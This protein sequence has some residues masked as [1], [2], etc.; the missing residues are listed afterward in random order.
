MTQFLIDQGLLQRETTAAERVT[1][2]DISQRAI[3]L[4]K[5]TLNALGLT[6]PIQKLLLSDDKIRQQ[7]GLEHGLDFEDIDCENTVVVNS[8]DW[9]QLYGTDGD[10]EV[11]AVVDYLSRMAAEQGF[12]VVVDWPET[13]YEGDQ[14]HPDAPDAI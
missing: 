2:T 1:Q 11:K 6:R 13:A 7:A 4:A 5:T 3:E 9:G 10:D 12:E 14:L 8:G